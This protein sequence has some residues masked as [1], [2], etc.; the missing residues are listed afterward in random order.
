[1]KHLETLIIDSNFFAF[2]Y[3]HHVDFTTEKLHTIKL[4]DDL[5]FNYE[6]QIPSDD[7][8]TFYDK[9]R[10]FIARQHFLRGDM[11]L[12]FSIS[13]FDQP[14]IIPS[15]LNKLEFTDRMRFSFGSSKEQLQNFIDFIVGQVELGFVKVEIDETSLVSSDRMKLREWRQDLL[16]LEID[17]M[18]VNTHPLHEPQTVSHRST[19]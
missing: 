8:Q 11:S 5:K 19:K 2:L 9:V 15:K 14:I 18:E 16:N 10:A 4:F 6:H 7:G 12:E 1:M 17:M 3:D 13:F